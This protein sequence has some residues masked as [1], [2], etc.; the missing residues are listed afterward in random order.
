[1][2]KVEMT[3]QLAGFKVVGDYEDLDELYNAIWAIAPEADMPGGTT[4]SADD[5]AMRIRVLALCYDLR[6]CMQGDRDVELVDSGLSD[7]CAQWNEIPLVEKN[8]AYSFK[9]LYP[10]AMYELLVLSCLI[11]KRRAFL[12]RKSGYASGANVDPALLDHAICAVRRYQSL[13]LAAVE[14]EATSGRF[15]RIRS[16]VTDARTMGIALMYGQ[17]LD[18]IDCDWTRMTR[19]KRI[20]NMSTVVR[21]IAEYWRHDQYFEMKEDIDRFVAKEQIDRSNVVIP[22]AQ[23]SEPEEW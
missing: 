19:K 9:V 6:H 12:S 10:E 23:W 18:V 2:L 22:T 20:E 5:H 14:K 16:Y 13:L 15:D 1:M 17:W 8:V 7:F 21:D 4:F 3:P 11:E